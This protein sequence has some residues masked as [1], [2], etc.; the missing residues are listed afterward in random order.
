MNLGTV[1]FLLIGVVSGSCYVVGC[2]SYR[3]GGPSCYYWTG[4]YLNYYGDGYRPSR[5]RER[6]GRSGW[7]VLRQLGLNYR[8]GVCGS[9]YRGGNRGRIV[10]K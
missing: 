7:E 5:R 10:G 8:S 1:F 9:S 2:G 3:R 6:D 4:E